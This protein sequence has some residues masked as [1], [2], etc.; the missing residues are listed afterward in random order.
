MYEGMYSMNVPDMYSNDFASYD[1]FPFYEILDPKEVNIKEKFEV[2]TSSN[3]YT[4]IIFIFL[5]YIF[6]KF[7]GEYFSKFDSILYKIIIYIFLL[8]PLVYIIFIQS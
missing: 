3:N 6:D 8:V 5:L 7:F 1:K 4:I 2:P